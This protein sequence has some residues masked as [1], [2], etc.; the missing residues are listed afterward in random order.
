MEMSVFTVSSAKEQRDIVQLIRVRDRVGGTLDP[1]ALMPQLSFRGPDG[2]TRVFVNAGGG[3]S[4]Y[5]SWRD[6]DWD[7]YGRVVGYRWRVEVHPGTTWVVNAVRHY[8]AEC[9]LLTSTA[10]YA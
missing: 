2:R 3:S 1:D 10:V 4:Y 6:L 5:L 7:V 9:G 8:L